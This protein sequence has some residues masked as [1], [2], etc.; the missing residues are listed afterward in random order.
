MTM[1]IRVTVELTPVKVY[2][3]WYLTND[4]G[5]ASFI[6][7]NA[8]LFDGVAELKE[9]LEQHPLYHD[10]SL[11]KCHT[12]FDVTVER[13]RQHY[14]PCDV[15]GVDDEQHERLMKNRQ[16]WF[17]DEWFYCTV[18][19]S[20]SFNGVHLGDHLATL[21]GIEANYPGSDNAYLTE[22]ANELLP[23]ALQ[24]AFIEKSELYNKITEV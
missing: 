24:R 6:E 16:A 2:G 8:E 22:V 4:S 13:V 11:M 12:D 14:G 9:E 3:E 20:V 5:I 15:T 10:A 19:L 21:S 7:S 18:V 1:Q 23:E 17:N